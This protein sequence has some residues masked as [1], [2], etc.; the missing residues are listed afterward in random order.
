M[1]KATTIKVQV[2][3]SKKLTISEINA[4]VD[5]TANKI[6]ETIDKYNKSIWET[7]EYKGKVKAIKTKYKVL[8]ADKELVR[9]KQEY[10]GITFSVAYPQEVRD[11]LREL[12]NAT[13]TKYRKQG[14]NNYNGSSDLKNIKN[15]LILE[16]VDSTLSVFELAEKIAQ[17]YLSK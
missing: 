9:L 16:Q 3:K 8:K 1:A 15:R 12:D 17:E 2:S 10:P 4:L 14:I 11:E 5:I 6:N 7:P 13:R